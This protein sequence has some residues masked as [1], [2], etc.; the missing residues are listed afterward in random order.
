MD[1]PVVLLV[2]IK[3]LHL[4]KSRLRAT[5]TFGGRSPAGHM[6]LVLAMAGDTIAAARA[7]DAVS[8]V[9]VIT[10]DDRVIRCM[11]KA[12]VESILE[13]GPMGLNEALGLGFRTIDARS[14]GR[15]IGALNADLPA[16]RPRDLSAAIRLGAGRRAFCRDRLGTGTT[17][18][19]AGRGE[20]LTPRFGPW[21]ASAHAATGAIDLPGSWPSLRCDVDT[22]N[23]LE[24]ALQLGLGEETR[25]LLAT[26]AARQARTG[27]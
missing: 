1:A 26:T 4:A 5:A 11:A 2:P 18:L 24:S 20:D 17:L 9:V 7:A 22:E 3:P 23:D 19:L 6:D 14:P 25:S 13:P 27:S 21:S 12:G 15:L 16:L 8:E 10:S